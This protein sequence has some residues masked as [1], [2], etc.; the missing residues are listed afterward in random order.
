MDALVVTMDV[1]HAAIDGHIAEKEHLFAGKE[2]AFIAKGGSIGR[3]AG[4]FA[5]K[6]RD[7]ERSRVVFA[8]MRGEYAT[9]RGHNGAKRVFFA[10][11]GVHHATIGASNVA[12]EALITAT[13]A[14]NAATLRGRPSSHG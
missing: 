1:Y 3:M 9:M 2:V 13:C 14:F 11:M 12:M 7:C 4:N 5:V 8:V 6:S 10:A